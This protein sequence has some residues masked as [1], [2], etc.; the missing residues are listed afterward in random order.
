MDA[1]RRRRLSQRLSYHL[2]HHPDELDLELDRAGWAP[3]PELL[4]ALARRG[5]QLTAAELE[6]IVV[7]SDKQ[8]F[9]LAFGAAWVRAR[10]GH[11]VDVELGYEPQ[12]PPPVLFHGTATRHVDGILREGLLPRSRQQ[13]HLSEDVATATRV[14]ARHGRPVILQVDA[15]A[16]T[17]DGHELRRAAPGIWLVDR[18]P[19]RY[20]QRLDDGR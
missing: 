2:R 17:G 11:S 12:Q 3:V 18:V 7:T 4:E 13:V 15:T 10:Y 9:E 5:V 14:G 8:R 1:Q 19:A 16:L 6:Q 20:L